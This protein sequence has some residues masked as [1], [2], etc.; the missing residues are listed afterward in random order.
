MPVLIA[1]L[2]IIAT[3]AYFIIRARNATHAA[4]ELLDVANDVRLAARRFGFRRRSNVHPVEAL[5][6]SNLALTTAALSFLQ[7]DGPT[8]QDV[9][10]R[11]A[12]QLRKTCDLD[13]SGAE[14]AIILG[15]W[16]I[17]ECG[18]ANAAFSRA[19]RKLQKMTGVDGLTPLLTVI[20]GSLPGD[21]LSVRQNEGL[22]DLKRV[23]RV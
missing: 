10:D 17:S 7:L 12:I 5:E 13:Q 14:E 21:G 11:F 6:D 18:D 20:K 4:E 19:S 23:F 15:R 22:E 3:A 8:T 9:L 1:L 16:L 2:G